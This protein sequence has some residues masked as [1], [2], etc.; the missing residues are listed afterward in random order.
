MS[1]VS[2]IKIIPSTL[3]YKSAPEVDNNITIELDEKQQ[4]LIETDR[5][6]NV[7]LAQVYD[8]ERQR[9]TTFRPTAKLNFLFENVFFGTTSYKPFENQ[10]YYLQPESSVINLSLWSGFPQYQE[11]NFIRNDYDIPNYTTQGTNPPHVDFAAISSTTYNWSVYL[12][13]P[14]RNNLTKTLQHYDGNLNITWTAQEG[15]PFYIEN[16]V[17]NGSNYISFRCPM[18]HGL[19]ENEFVELSIAYNGTKV[20]Q[21]STLGDESF[22]S[23]LYIFNIENIGYTGNTFAN[24]VKGTFKRIIDINY[25]SETKSEYYVRE[26]KILTED[27]DTILV[28]SGFEQNGFNTQKIYQYSALTPNNVGRIA[29]KDGNQTYTITFKKDI[30][31]N[32]LLDNQTRP[33][34]ELFVTIVNKGYFGWFNFAPLTGSPALKFG[35]EFNIPKLANQSNPWWSN[36]NNL[37]WTNIPTNSYTRGGFTFNYNKSLPVGFIID[38]DFCEFNNTE[39]AERVISKINHKLRYNPSVF[40]I[41][42]NL[43]PNPP[44]YYYQV[45]FPITLRVFSNYIET[46]NNEEITAAPSYA[47]YSESQ[48]SFLWRDIY[49]YGYRDNDERGVDYPFINGNHYPYGEI[50]FRLSSGYEDYTRNLQLIVQPK[51]DKCA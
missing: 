51:F 39:Q 17:F 18:N 45:H 25:S 9:S 30:D 5:S 29:E 15:I 47:Y 19:T 14:F 21:V 4:L 40:K 22:G 10:L 32:D 36:T 41:Q 7:D 48:Q 28:K 13:Y 46:A 26:H 1:N 6:S 35:Y 8:D 31:I 50:F 27:S 20:F 34:T 16:T 33:L 38:G 2:D 37:S 23:E 11:F 3:K 12:S 24:G 42:T 44:G 43:T 49:T